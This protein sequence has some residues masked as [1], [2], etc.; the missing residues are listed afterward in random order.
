VEI[1]QH[2]MDKKVEIPIS[3]VALLQ[4]CI[5]D[6]LWAL[7]RLMS[8]EILS[9]GAQNGFIKVLK[10]IGA[11][12]YTSNGKKSKPRA[13]DGSDRWVDLPNPFTNL[14]VDGMGRGYPSGEPAD[15]QDIS[16][17][18]V[19]STDK[20]PLFTLE[21]SKS[22][23]LAMAMA[24][25]SDVHSVRE[26]VKAL[27]TDYKAGK[28]DLLT[29]SVTTNTALELLSRQHEDLVKTVLPFFDNDARLLGVELW[30]AATQGYFA[31]PPPFTSLTIGT[32]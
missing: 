28:I 17:P 12:L 19:D 22:E 26:H 29:A 20:A 15:E 30:S 11:Q 1:A 16:L 5:R 13:K 9:I 7:R 21:I 25:L 2:N 8:S 14:D 31:D 18:P 32:K 4:G 27:W 10:A 23:G 6:R 3:S 24:F